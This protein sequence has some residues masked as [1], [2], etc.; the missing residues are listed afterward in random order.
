MV[1]Y[2]QQA[3][4]TKKNLYNTVKENKHIRLHCVVYVQETFG[5]M[6]INTTKT[7]PSSSFWGRRQAGQICKRIYK[8]CG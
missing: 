3:K 6:M 7:H 2:W 8:K 5:A 4:K 1:P